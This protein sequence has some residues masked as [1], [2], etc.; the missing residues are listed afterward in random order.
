MQ[1]AQGNPP[2]FAVVDGLGTYEG[3]YQLC[4]TREGQT[5]MLSQWTTTTNWTD[6]GSPYLWWTGVDGTHHHGHSSLGP[7]PGRLGPGQKVGVVVSDQA[8]DQDALDSYLLP[9]LKKIG[10]IPEVVTVTADIGETS[11]TDSTATWRGTGSRR[12]GSSR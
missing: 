11:S 6:L 3:T 1:V 2:V 5:P 12:R 4:I 8:S 10:V 7:E 9:D